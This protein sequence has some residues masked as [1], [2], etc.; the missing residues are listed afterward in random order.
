MLR[1]S[2]MF[3]RQK[4]AQFKKS[5]TEIA[6]GEEQL[7]KA[8]AFV[9]DVADK[10]EDETWCTYRGALNAHALI[11]LHQLDYTVRDDGENMAVAWHIS[12]ASG[13]PKAESPP[14]PAPT[15]KLFVWHDAFRDYM[16]GVMFALAHTTDEAREI[17]SPGYHARRKG[18]PGTFNRE[19]SELKLEP[20]VY[21]APAG[22]K[23]EGG[24]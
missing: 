20:T 4:T 1:A 11:R 3:A 2:E 18:L 12:W 5:Q 22:F 16:A 13:E 21:T 19:D 9:E 23:V 7:A 17:I 10:G 24:G 14:E 6:N 15:L 8:L